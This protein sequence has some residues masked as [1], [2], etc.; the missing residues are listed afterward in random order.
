[1]DAFGRFL[2]LAGLILSLSGC[3][4]AA[5]QGSSAPQEKPPQEFAVARLKAAGIS[6]RMIELL[7]KAHEPE[8]RDR[9]VELNVLGFLGKGDYEA[10]YSSRAIRKCRAFLKAH[11]T[12]LRRAEKS[13]GVPREVITALLWVETKLGTHIGRHSVADVYFS[14]IQADHPEVV[15][16]TLSSLATRAPASADELKQKVLDRSASKASWAI[17][18]LR[19]LDEIQKKQP[20]R[21]A[22]LRGSYAGAFGIPQ[23]VPSSYLQWARSARRNQVPD[24]FRMDDAI[25]SVAFYLKSNGWVAA[26]R[27]SHREALF[28]YN[29]AQGYVDVILK[30][31]D[32]LKKPG[33]WSGTC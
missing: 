21:I 19:S 2:A 5:G 29:R 9:I 27:E 1:M 16:A 4:S 24:L 25:Q 33:N 20:A 13:T 12:R 17:N 10:H 30:I 18:E 23:F 15:R 26:E 11:S 7:Q 31:A 14:L 28:H 8:S 32:C 22:S 6:E 3:A